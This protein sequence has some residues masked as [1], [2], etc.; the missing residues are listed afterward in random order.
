MWYAFLFWVKGQRRINFSSHPF[1]SFSRLHPSLTKHV[2][3]LS[4]GGGRGDL[5]DLIPSERA[6][7][8]KNIAALTAGDAQDSLPLRHDYHRGF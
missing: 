1:P 5:L 6:R 3:S 7:L 2:L 4:K 8:K